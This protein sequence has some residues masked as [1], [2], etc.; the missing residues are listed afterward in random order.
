MGYYV[1]LPLSWVAHD[2]N[3]LDW[4]IS[5]KI[6]PELGLD[7]TALQRPLSWHE[8]LAWKLREANLACAVHLPFMELSPAD[9]DPDERTR[10]GRLLRRA[11]DLASV[12]NARH[13]IGH[14]GYRADR[15]GTDAGGLVP[16]PGWLDR[17]RM[18]WKDLPERAGSPL[19]LENV[20]DP[21]PA[22]L[23]AL[24]AALDAH[25]TGICFD[26]GHW[27]CFS[28]GQEKKDLK[29][30]VR[31]Y[32]PFLRHLH[33]HDNDGAADRHAGLGQGTLPLDDLVDCL[34]CQSLR[35]SA[36]FEPHTV[37]AFMETAAWFGK[38]PK[39]AKLLRW[40]PPAWSGKKPP[41]SVL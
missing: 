6:S 36:T 8:G 32:S 17:S 12:Y 24:L 29:Q 1:N 26:A 10:A 2:A 38:H 11:A 37:A 41:S 5:E 40:T 33:L 14:P 20:Y 31:A 4:F 22:V 15:H 25:G 28:G 35:P 34:E 9:Q 19:F 13:M 27:H 30:W 3:W 39:A 7:A 16:H 18:A 21:S 23:Q